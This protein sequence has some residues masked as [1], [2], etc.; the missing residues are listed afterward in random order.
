MGGTGWCVL[1]PLP[2]ARIE[3]AVVAAFRAEGLVRH[4]ARVR[5]WYDAAGRPYA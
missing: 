1:S 5:D 2:A 3:P 4:S